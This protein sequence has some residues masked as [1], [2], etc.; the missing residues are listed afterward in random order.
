MKNSR[1]IIISALSAISFFTIAWVSNAEISPAEYLYALEAGDEK[2]EGQSILTLDD[3]IPNTKESE[4][5]P[6]PFNDQSWDPFPSSG[7]NGSMYLKDPS[8]IQSEFSYDVE[9]GNYNYEQ[10]LG[11]R[12]YRS[13]VY[14]TFDEYVNY[15]MD[16]ST[17]DYW[18][19]KIDAE[20]ID[21]ENP[22]IPKIHVGGEA[23]DRIFGGNIVDI[24][25]QGTAE[26][27]FG[28]MSNRIDNPAIPERNR[29]QTAF[30]FNQ[31]IQLNVVGNIGEKLKLTTSYNTEATFDFENQ[32]KLEYT[33][34]EDE[35]IKKIE[36]G[37][38]NL[39]LTGSLIT[40]SQSLFGIK[41][42]LQFGR[43][44]VTSVFSQQRGKKQEVETSGGAQTSYFDISADNYEYNKH[45]FLANYFRENYD[46]SMAT[47]PI[48]SSTVNITKVEVWITNTNISS[49][50]NIRNVV[51][52]MDLGEPNFYHQSG[53]ITQNSGTYPDNKVNSLYD[54][55]SNLEPVR[56]FLQANSYLNNQTQLE[57]AIDYDVAQ[58]ARLL[59]PAE[60]TFH[61]QLG[62]ISL[63]QTL[64]PDQVLSVAFQYTVGGSPDI[65]QVGEFST[66][67]INGEKAL[68]LK[69]LKSTNLNTQIPL[70]DLM[71]KNIYSIGA[72][73]VNK[74]GFKLDVV[75]NSIEQG[76]N[77]PYLPEG[78]YR[79]RP[80]IQVLGLDRLNAQEDASSDGVFDFLPGRTINP[81]NGRIYFPVIEPFGSHLR[82]QITGGDDNLQTVANKYVFEPLYDTTKIAAQQRPDL[83]RFRIKGSYQSTSSSEISLNA[84]NVPQGSVVVTAGGATLVEGSDYTVDYTL[85]RVK[86]I[87]ASL[88]ESNTPIKVSLE[89]NQLFAI[90]SKS[91]FGTHLDYK[92]SNDFTVGAT[93]M[94][95]T[96]RPLTQKV[97]FGDE[98]MSNTIWG[99]DANYR[100]DA[101]IL[102]K[103]VDKLPFLATK[104]MSTIT[105]QGEFAHLIPGNSKAIGKEG[106]SYLDDFEGSQSVIDIRS[107]FAWS[108]ASTPQKQTNLFPEANF[109]NDLR[110]GFN[111]AK[112]AWYTIDPLFWR[113][114][115]LTPTHIKGSEMQ[116]NHYMREI[117]ET[118]IFPNRVPPQGQVM[119]MPVLD[120]A[121]Y[122][123]EKGPYNY[124]VQPSAY[125]AGIDQNGLLN[126]PAS[127][128]AG[129]M[130]KIDQND[131]E[132]ANIEYIQFWVM[133]PFHSD[134]G[135]AT[136]SGGDLYFN[137]GN[138]SEDILRDDRK[139]FE[140]GLPTTAS[141]TNVDTTAWGRVSSLQSLVN[142]F[143]TKEEARPFQDIGYDGL[144]DE[145]EKTF[146]DN[147]YLANIASIY[148][149]NSPAY[150]KA[151]QDPSGDN[152][153]YFRGTAQDDDQRNILERYKEFNGVEG[154]S[155]TSQNETEAFPTASSPSPNIEDI[156]RDNT[157]STNESYYQYKVS[158]RPQDMVVGQNYITDKVT[159]SGK[160]KDGE[161][162]DVDW[163]QFKIP[164]RNPEKVIGG[165]QDFTSIRFVRMFL[166]GFT[167]SVICRFGRLELVRG[168]W[169]KY[170]YDLRSPGEYL[171]DDASGSTLFDVG[172]VNIEENGVKT[173]VNYILPPG[174]D[175]VIDAANPQLRR[176]NEQSM[177]LKACD[178]EDGDAKAAYRNTNFDVRSYK[179]L[180]MF[181]HAEALNN[182]VLNDGDLRL[183]VRLGRDY[184]EN[185]YEYE[186]PLVV[187]PPG[188]YNGDSEAD[189]IK[190]WPL[191][192][193]I[194][195]PFEL[196]TALKLD[197]NA[198]QVPFN[199]PYTRKN[200]EH[201]LAVV[202]N[203]QLSEISS[204]MI[205]VRN[206]KKEGT[207]D[208]DDGFAKCVEIW[209]NELR[210]SDFDKRNGWATTGRVSAKLADFGDVTVA[211][212][213]STPGFGSIEKKISERQ[214][215]DIRSYDLSGNF[216]MGR[217]LP[218][219]FNLSIPM[220]LGYSEGFINPQFHP[221]DPDIE[222]DDL[223]KIDDKSVRD[224][225][226][227]S[228]QDYTRRRS[229]NFANVKKEKGKGASKSRIYDV[230]NLSF[231]Y[232]YNEIFK[233]DIN[234]E[235][236]ETKL[237]RGAVM[238]SFSTSPKNIKPFS[239]SK[240]LNKSKYAKLITDFNFNLMPSR[241]SFST[242]LDRMF[243]EVQIRNNSGFADYVIP[244]TFNKNFTMT[245]MY[246][247]R[248]DITKSLKFDF[249][250][251]NNA[252]IMEPDG[253]I[254]TQ[255][256]K[257]SI[258]QSLKE[259]GT[260]VLYNHAMNLNYTWPINKF[261]LTDWVNLTTRIGGTYDW[262]RAP[263]AANELGNT[264]KN[265]RSEQWN[266]Q[267]NFLTLYNKVPYL[268]KV[269]QKYS[270]K[271][272]AR[273]APKPPVPKPALPDS[274]K[275]KEKEKDPNKF[276][277][278]EQSARVIMSVK[279][280]SFTYTDNSGTILP[281]YS[282]PTTLL[283]MDNFNAPGWGFISGHQDTSFAMRAVREGWLMEESLLMTPY[284]TT[285]SKN[286]NAR[287]NI[288]P[289]KDLRLELNVTRNVG[290]SNS[291][292][293]RWNDDLGEFV[294]E[295]RMETGNFSMSYVSWNTSFIRDLEDGSSPVF[296]QFM[297]NRIAIS[298][299]LANE[300]EAETGLPVGVNQ[301]GYREG[302][303][304]TSQ[305]VLIPAFLAAYSGT[306]A[307]SASTSL[308]PKIPKPNW[309][310]TYDG[311]SKLDLFKKY[312]KSFTLSHAYRSSYNI[313]SY[314]TNMLFV[315][316]AGPGYTDKMDI[317][318]NYIPQFQ[319]AQISITEQFSP[320]IN[321][322][323]TWH[324]SLITR[325]ELKR[326]RNLAFNFTDNRLQESKGNEVIVGF[327]YRFK[328]V[329]FPFKIGP[330]KTKVQSDLNCRADI[331]VRDNRIMM[332]SIDDNL[333]QPTGGQ[334]I[335]SIK[336]AAD[337]VLNSRVNLRLFFDKILT[338][339]VITNSFPSSNT[340]AGISLR[341]TLS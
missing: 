321:M 283:G 288:E 151:L 284:A 252:R 189:R 124:D 113:D 83:N 281:G 261:P 226:K 178:L 13:P 121:L 328:N 268:K 243:N 41:T 85:G 111:R 227:E 162:I 147:I 299:K 334:R 254:D 341:F 31:K 165:I 244:P 34:Y 194:D 101:P 231:T 305:D 48:I 143:D 142:A 241:L 2:T 128:W 148:G 69:L 3:T 311:L 332:R 54:K 43:L 250:A 171:A 144:S 159:G 173:P 28:V 272:G 103:L 258:N 207:D 180:K 302:Y 110:Y 115:N 15:K 266:G 36:A 137:L 248:H 136:H 240:L 287:T 325:I 155:K 30:D 102:T 211:G 182:Q 339:P 5:L 131:F 340:N 224:S 303:G 242:S 1:N 16:K 168:E 172:A 163:Y 97:N 329:P 89:S 198:A 80:L 66:D 310:I 188:K 232:S 293:I 12:N 37:N 49:T 154:N 220:F 331:S 8:N 234:T 122:P 225:I 108:L 157:L 167:D 27:I 145:D 62:F 123:N 247:V 112:L 99:L 260:N 337:Y 134:N 51:G 14:M 52:F 64:N 93:I 107:S 282:K 25:P 263:F 184:N 71:M 196:L 138:I 213:M 152:F 208:S 320:L 166:T 46:N 251:T 212:N 153:K 125:S 47:M 183:F 29:R 26:L 190:V 117:L 118:E 6:F 271:G 294:R 197:R 169:R 290:K 306:D 11:D 104:E 309:R 314:S 292:F 160:T 205:G 308:M 186:I 273:Q 203:P 319:I 23:F 274:L 7:S 9:T 164:V 291:E 141:V 96:E 100:T 127:R 74:E 21:K 32:M 235:Y 295:S 201:V 60:Y 276:N 218:E 338:S 86:I 38:V 322:D 19:Q 35:I 77:I 109:V 90:Q 57:F 59:T 300:R 179:K 313:G 222:F 333:H 106:V 33:G 259:L 22:I 82:K 53:Y 135:V 68:V 176:L 119:N 228:V 84:M 239:K 120:L 269:N 202:G 233:R 286:F 230:E 221:N 193:E 237:Y 156:N 44:T 129:I 139:S 200:G 72:Y 76:I 161:Q 278:Y 45:F 10:K 285:N 40:G 223:L 262:M 181:V 264:I 210:L 316:N 253:K 65:Y 140:H 330:T 20:T 50:T 70:W 187:T 78:A 170:L 39:P 92:I 336:L 246:E 87:N 297:D 236:N 199:I 304:A 255:E 215:A 114:N 95:L 312:F 132:T 270:G 67:G 267:F 191:I 88:L 229:I 307:N 298:N 185:Y 257:D 335:I 279:N 280:A 317:N 204:I 4:P 146:F 296:Q 209:V 75:Y 55:V 91:L 17:K 24:K 301:D 177:V 265:S 217:L 249:T 175:R 315:E 195:L 192:N 216:R 42:Q 63:N 18:R 327:G 289:L 130:R 214:R 149:V 219:N 323:M 98:P 326:D 105:F 126:D 206:P 275:G 158:L 61:P 277:I 56:N 58:G 116:S 79:G 238:Y 133:D 318:D 81:Q 324:N 245:R 73:S 94:N 256:K 150:Q 174:I